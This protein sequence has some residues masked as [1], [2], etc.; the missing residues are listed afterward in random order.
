MWTG[1][2]FIIS[3]AIVALAV[4]WG[5]LA[6]LV[7]SSKA[8]Q[9][10]SYLLGMAQTLD[11]GSLKIIFST[12]QIIQSISITTNVAFPSPFADLLGSMAVLSLDTSALEC[13]AWGGVY[14]TVYLLTALPL[15]LAA[16]IALLG[17]GRVYLSSSV[18]RRAVIVSQHSWMIILLSYL[19]VPP[20]VTNSSRL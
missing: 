14:S 10:S 13:S 17:I 2:A 4:T 9:S 18:E 1:R 12:Y 8:V 19:V 7:T 15:I 3:A 20:V 6:R 5:C 16:L 11:S